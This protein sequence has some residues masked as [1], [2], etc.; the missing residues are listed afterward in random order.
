MASNKQVL[1]KSVPYGETK[2]AP[3]SAGFGKQLLVNSF[4]LL[5]RSG[6]R[7][8]VTGYWGFFYPQVGEFWIK[9]WVCRTGMSTG[10]VQA[11]SHMGIKE[12]RVRIGIY[13]A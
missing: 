2:P 9:D 13:F 6:Y 5:T 1:P 10:F 7:R 3:A 8:T 12:A 11:G 4:R